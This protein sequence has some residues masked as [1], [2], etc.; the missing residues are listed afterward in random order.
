MELDVLLIRLSSVTWDGVGWIVGYCFLKSSVVWKLDICPHLTDWL[1]RIIFVK[2]HIRSRTIPLSL[3]KLMADGAIFMRLKS[4]PIHFGFCWGSGFFFR[5]C[6]V[7]LLFS[8]FQ[9][10]CT[11]RVVKSTGLG[12]TDVFSFKRNVVLV[13]LYLLLLLVQVFVCLIFKTS[14]FAMGHFVL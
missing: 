1:N 13:S 8:F 10:K 14:L 7:S 4:E 11:W 12:I 3:L 5:R 9:I 6:I 2:D